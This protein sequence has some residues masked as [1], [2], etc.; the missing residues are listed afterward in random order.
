MIHTYNV[1]N[2][3]LN[4]NN[5]EKVEGETGSIGNANDEENNNNNN[6]NHQKLAQNIHNLYVLNNLKRIIAEQQ[7]RINV[8]SDYVP[9]R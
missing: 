6:N 3:H 7:A 8:G 4:N 2:Y 9:S 1:N 5:M